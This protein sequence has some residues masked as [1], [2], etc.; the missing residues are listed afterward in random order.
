MT[1]SSGVVAMVTGMVKQGE[2]QIAH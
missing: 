2:V 1:W